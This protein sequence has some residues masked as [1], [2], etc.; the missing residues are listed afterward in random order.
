MENLNIILSVA[1]VEFVIDYIVL[2][3]FKIQYRK[4]YLLFLQIPKICA[5]VLCLFY[6][7]VFLLSLL[8][9]I[10]ADFVC[11]IFI[12]DSFKFSRLFN[13]FISKVIFFFSISGFV[14]FLVVWLRISI[15]EIFK[16]KI[17]EKYGFLIILSIFVYIFAIFC[18]VRSI[19]KNKFLNKYLAKVSF[20]I[21]NKHINLY[22]LVDSGNSL[23]D[24]IS[25]MPVVLVSI[26]SLKKILNESELNEIINSR[27]R[28]IKCD[29]V[30]GSGFE[31]PI[32]KASDFI[33]KFDQET[34]RFFCM[35]G[36]IEQGFGNDKFDCLLHRDFI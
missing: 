35:V 29:T 22:G 11:I 16:V 12:T 33:A 28:K 27:C 36:I 6:E 24:P 2:K 21:N 23:L 31:I 18:L 10:L 8:I 34:K 25:R 17:L 15:F 30:S 5:N 32:F 20:K 3:L 1:I 7:F 26:K 13:L 9:K 4:I 19:D 14:S